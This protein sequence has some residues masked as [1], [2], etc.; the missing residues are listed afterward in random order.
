MENSPYNPG[1][2]TAQ[3]STFVNQ[4]VNPGVIQIR[5]DTSQIMIDFADSLRG[6]QVVA[7]YDT[8]TRTTDY[9]RVKVGERLVNEA[10]IQ[11]LTMFLR[12]IVSSHGVQGNWTP[13]Y[14][15]NF[16]CESDK[17]LS[18]NIMVNREKWEIDLSDYNN[19]CDSI[20]ALVQQFASRLIDNKERESYGSTIRTSE[21]VVQQPAKGGFNLFGGG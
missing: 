5:L 21:S 17:N 8:K 3:G 14:F 7:F 12:K 1:S 13:V 2:A 16:I 15:E 9:K 4:G 18:V 10:G 20:I 6:E 11:S 19:I